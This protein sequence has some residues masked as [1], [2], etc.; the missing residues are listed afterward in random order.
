MENFMELLD[1]NK[2]MDVYGYFEDKIKANPQLLVVLYELD[3]PTKFSEEDNKTLANLKEIQESKHKWLAEMVTHKGYYLIEDDKKHKEIFLKIKDKISSRHK[4]NKIN[5]VENEWTDIEL[6][7]SEKELP[8]AYV[9]LTFDDDNFKIKAEV[10]DTHFLDGNRAWRYGDGFFMNFTMPEGNEIKDCISTERFYGLGFSMENGKPSGVLVNHNGTYYLG[11]SDKLSVEIAIDND[12][13][14]AIYEI[15]IPFSFLKPFNPIVDEISGF[16]IRYISQ[17]KERDSRIKIQLIDDIHA[18]SEMTNHR[19]FV[20]VTYSFSKDSSFK[21]AGMVNNRLAMKDNLKI[22]LHYYSTKEEEENLSIQ[23]DNSENEI[24][25]EMSETIKI[26]KG[27]HKFSEEINLDDLK[28]GLYQLKVKIKDK[29]WTETFYKYSK[30]K[31]EEISNEIKNLE[32]MEATPLIESSI[33]TIKYKLQEIDSFISKFHY[34]ENPEFIDST[35][36]EIDSMVKACQKD[37]SI[38]KKSGYVLSAFNSP[39]DDTLQPYSLSLPENFDPEK[40][41]YL[42]VGLHGSGVDEVGFIRFMGRNLAEMEATN[43]IL[44]GPRGRHL[45]DYYTGQTEKDVVDM[46][47][48]VKKL[49][50]IKKTIIFGFSMGGYGCWRMSLKYPELFEAAII[51]AGMPYFGSK[52]ENDMRT[53]AEKS[54]NIDYLVIHS[55]DDRS[56]SIE[57]TDEFIEILKGKNFAVQY[58]R[59]SGMDHG[60]MDYGEL[61]G[62]W[63]A[64]YLG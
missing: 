38:F 56:V 48:V 35:F 13:M 26:K 54:N 50:K 1:Q 7:H 17:D 55:E 45:S 37:K 9:A 36:K 14:V 57:E 6:V 24:V 40:E 58:E 59:L 33:N 64:K 44:V 4:K 15:S 5:L 3:Y 61:V 10:H 53:F 27:K 52:P 32:Q 46:L 42:M 34:R 20:P 19:R 49:F 18:D 21:F 16:Y 31:S 22:D 62:M 39:A 51:V 60:N 11:K 47:N 12:K 2:Y 41:Y 63:L 23:L 43:L 30:I 29:T 25:L 8:K 28:P